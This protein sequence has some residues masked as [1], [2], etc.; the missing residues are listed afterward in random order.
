MAERHSITLRRKELGRLLRELRTSRGHSLDDVAT[1]LMCS[2]TKISRMESGSRAVSGR[3]VRD[4]CRF[5]GIEKQEQDRLM[6]I[7]SESRQ[8]SWWQT[9]DLRYGTFIDL[10]QSASII[11]EYQTVVIPGLVQTRD[12]ASALIHAVMPK[13]RQEE[14]DSRVKARMERQSLLHQPN[15]PLF[16][17]VIDELA[18]Q[19]V[20]GSP[21][22]MAEQMKHLV[23]ASRLPNVNLQIIPIS[24][25]VYPGYPFPF[26][27]LEFE[28]AEMK[29]VVYVEGN[30]GDAYL[31]R[32]SDVTRCKDIIDQLRASGHGT[33]DSRALFEAARQR[34]S[35]NL[36][37]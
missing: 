7:A 19:R 17:G 29:S 27:L 37:E 14:L 3:D 9:Y 11:T 24:A 2:T 35:H 33:N 4:L 22:I 28:Q 20:I 36:S 30:F 1:E 12:Y 26:S 31:E 10:E 21:S 34:F 16:W 18:L 8:S 23:E 15:P 32:L 6:E 25:Q 5:Y 13:L